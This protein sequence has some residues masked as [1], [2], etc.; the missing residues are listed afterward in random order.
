MP[1]SN[2]PIHNPHVNMLN[3]WPQKPTH[4]FIKALREEEDEPA[5]YLLGPEPVRARG[6]LL[7]HGVLLFRHKSDFQMKE[8]HVFL[9]T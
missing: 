4:F 5:Q 6:V 3:T 2:L 1:D 8:R 9:K 7:L